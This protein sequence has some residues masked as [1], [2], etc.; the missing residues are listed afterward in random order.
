MK[1]NGHSVKHVGLVGKCEDQTL[2]KK[3]N[4]SGL[5]R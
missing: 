5:D 1:L 2:P 4:K 3:K